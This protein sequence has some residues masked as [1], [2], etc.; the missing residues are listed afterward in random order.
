MAKCHKCGEYIDFQEHYQSRKLYPV[1]PEYV[2]HEELTIGQ[3]LITDGG[4]IMS[5]DPDKKLP[6]VKGRVIH[7]DTCR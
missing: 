3:R 1:D 6:S 7:F 4:N 2:R 5:Y